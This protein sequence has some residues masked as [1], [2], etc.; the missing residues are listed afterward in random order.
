MKLQ[1]E[2]QENINE[3][4]PQDKFSHLYWNP[5]KNG[6]HEKKSSTNL[7]TKG[8]KASNICF[9]SCKSVKRLG[10]HLQHSTTLI[11]AKQYHN[12]QRK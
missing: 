1:K 5:S 11:E 7:M 8:S 4:S 3:T 9:L 12:S 10:R 6:T 2:Q